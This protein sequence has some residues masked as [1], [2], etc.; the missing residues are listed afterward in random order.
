M[1]FDEQAKREVFDEGITLMTAAFRV[2]FAGDDEAD[3]RYRAYWLALRDLDSSEISRGFECALKRETYC[4]SPAKIREYAGSRDPE[5]LAKDVVSSH[6]MPWHVRHRRDPDPEVRAE[7]QR[8]TEEIRQMIAD[9]KKRF[10]A[11]PLGGFAS[12]R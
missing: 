6:Q 7:A 12:Q 11:G 2:R 8:Q 9:L 4:P 3:A 5:R 10:T 1:A